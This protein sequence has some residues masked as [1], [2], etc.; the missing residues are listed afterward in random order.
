MVHNLE[1]RLQSSK[2]N[3]EQIQKIMAMW[4]KAPL[5]ERFENKN[6]SLLNLS[7]RDDRTKRRYEEISSYGSKIH[8]FLQV[9]RYVRCRTRDLNELF[10]SSSSSSS[11][12]F[13]KWPKQQL[14][15]WSL[16]SLFSTNMAISETNGHSL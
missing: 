11:Q 3:V 9:R 15:S 2:D 8:E 4:S 5:F 6:S 16:T 13:L 10:T 7:D 12:V 14:V 1:S